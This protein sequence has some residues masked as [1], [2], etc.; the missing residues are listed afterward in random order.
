MGQFHFTILQIS[1]FYILSVNKFIISQ[2]IEYHVFHGI[3][4]G[5]FWFQE[6]WRVQLEFGNGEEIRIVL[7]HLLFGHLKGYKKIINKIQYQMERMDIK[8]IWIDL[9]MV[10][11]GKRMVK[12]LLYVVKTE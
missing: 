6:I 11:I 8:M 1:Q 7:E 12:V 2:E 5:N 4:M 3:K 10:Y 9:Y